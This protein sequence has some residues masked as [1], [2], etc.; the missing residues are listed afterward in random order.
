MSD[1]LELSDSCILRTDTDSHTQE[2]SK[3]P[4]RPRPGRPLWIPRFGNLKEGGDDDH[5]LKA[6]QDEKQENAK[7]K[8]KKKGK[9]ADVFYHV[10]WSTRTKIVIAMNHYVVVLL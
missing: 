1:S 4:P 3:N 5:Y 7:T 10:V 2:K 6:K 8:K 9:W